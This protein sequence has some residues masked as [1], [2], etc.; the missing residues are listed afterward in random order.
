MKDESVRN[1]DSI[2]VSQSPRTLIP[3]LALFLI[4]WFS[5]SETVKLSVL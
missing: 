5:S 1:A 4:P 3:R 2:F